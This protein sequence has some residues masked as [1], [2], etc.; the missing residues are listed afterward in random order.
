MTVE[1]AR[2]TV[3]LDDATRESFKAACQGAGDNV[4]S[5]L[6]R[7]IAELVSLPASHPIF[8]AIA[9]APPAARTGRLTILID[10]GLKK[11][12]EAACARNDYT[13]SQVVRRLIRA[14]LEDNEAA[15]R[16]APRSRKA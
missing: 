15:Q 14:W 10:A 5:V 9:V 16:P 11:R 4:S 13:V 7:L 2:L 6:R 1:E 3:L 12:L 8:N